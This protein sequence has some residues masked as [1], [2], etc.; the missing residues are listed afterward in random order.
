MVDFSYWPS[1]C[2]SRVSYGM[3]NETSILLVR[4]YLDESDSSLY[5]RGWMAS[6]HT[7]LLENLTRFLFE[8]THAFKMAASYKPTMRFRLTG[9]YNHMMLAEGDMLLLSEHQSKSDIAKG[10]AYVVK[11]HPRLK[12]SLRTLI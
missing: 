7:G 6:Q 4:K 10:Y 2:L 8:Y 12:H 5:C 9:H 3:Q 1:D 11:Y